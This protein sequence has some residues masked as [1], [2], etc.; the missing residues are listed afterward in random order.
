MNERDKNIIETADLISLAEELELSRTTVRI[1]LNELAKLGAFTVGV[2]PLDKRKKVWELVDGF[3]A[4]DESEW[5]QAIQKYEELYM[6]RLEE[7]RKLQPLREIYG[8]TGQKQG[9]KTEENAP[10]SRKCDKGGDI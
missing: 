2:H 6:A 3:E 7:L 1:Y 5:E 9:E 8:F 10:N 4:K